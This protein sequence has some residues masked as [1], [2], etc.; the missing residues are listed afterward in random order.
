MAPSRRLVTLSMV[1]FIIHV[2]VHFV[3]PP[4]LFEQRFSLERYAQK[5]LQAVGDSA[6]ALHP[7]SAGD[8]GAFTLFGSMTSV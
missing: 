3:S 1:S 8:R 6:F 2:A 4:G 7:H 5:Q